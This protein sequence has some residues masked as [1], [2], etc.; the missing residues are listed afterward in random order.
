MAA[1]YPQQAV[2]LH[3]AQFMGHGAAVHIEIIR[4]MLAVKRN[5]KII[6]SVLCRL[7]RE[8][9]QQAAPDGFGAGMKDPAGQMQVFPR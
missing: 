2:S 8:I 7:K 3:L 5:L 6:P 9:G 4:Q 1:V